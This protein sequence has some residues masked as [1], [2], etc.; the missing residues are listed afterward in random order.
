[1]HPAGPKSD[2]D[3]HTT[4]MDRAMEGNID[5]VGIGALFGLFDYKY[6]VMGLMLH[7][8]HLEDTFGVGPHTV[9]VPRM[10]PARNVSI[11]NYPHL[12]TDK[13]FKRIVAVLRLALPYAGIILSTREE[14]KFREEVISLGVSQISTGSCTGVGGYKESEEGLG[15]AQFEVADH[16]TPKETIKSLCE[17]GYLPSYC[18]ACYR[19]GRTGDRFMQVAKSGQIHNLCYPNAMLTFK[20]YLDDYADQELKIIGNKVIE[21]NLNNIPNDKMRKQT[22]ERLKKVEN[23]ERDL[24]F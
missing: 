11:D 19:A 2:Y 16:R 5:D 24:F 8:K 14:P 18:T 12:V 21:E 15:E 3:Y 7:A 6:E 10:R 22:K 9:S 4:A 23:G 13:E 20:E 1:M 17:Q